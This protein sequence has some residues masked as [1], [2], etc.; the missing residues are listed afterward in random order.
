V[1]VCAASVGLWAP[2]LAET[3]TTDKK[4]WKDE[5]ELS[6]VLTGGNTRV[7]T[8]HAK[9]NLEYRFTERLTGKWMFDLLY[10][11]DGGEQNAGRYRTELRADFALLERLFTY[12]LGGLSKDTFAD[13][14]G[15]YYVGAGLG[16]AVLAGP[17]H[18]LVAEAGLNYNRERYTRSIPDP[19]PPPAYLPATHEDFVM[20]RLFG[21]YVLA[22]TDRSNFTQ[23]LEYFPNLKETIDYILISE[24]ALTAA[25]NSYLSLKTSYTLKYDQ[26]PAGTAGRTDTI[27]GAAVVVTL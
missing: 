26:E 3:E 19:T 6:Y 24:T 5:L 4:V 10:G 9:N 20:G 8:F 18:T 27:V 1:L 21:K 11:E 16:Y 7:Q 15:R 13:I 14:D 22:F 23:S 17:T 2:A 25:V 12:G